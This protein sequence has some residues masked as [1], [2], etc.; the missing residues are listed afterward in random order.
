MK[1]KFSLPIRGIMSFEHDTPLEFGDW[2][3]DFQ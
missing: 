1:V 3:F 2:S